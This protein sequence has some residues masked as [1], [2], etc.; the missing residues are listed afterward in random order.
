MKTLDEIK[1]EWAK[2]HSYENYKEFMDLTKQC[3]ASQ[4][5]IMDGVVNKIAKLYAKE[6]A[7]EALKNASENAIMK[8]HCGHF[9]TDTP[10]QYHQQGADNI[11]ID[12][13]SIINERNIPEL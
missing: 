1:E 4:V 7:R 10:T 6:V 12:K 9:K 13:Q 11:Q 2:N 3:D 8:Y 5:F